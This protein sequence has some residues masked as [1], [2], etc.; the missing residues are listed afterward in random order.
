MVY[1]PEPVSP[2]RHLEGFKASL[3]LPCLPAYASAALPAVCK[4]RLSLCYVAAPATSYLSLL[5]AV[6]VSGS[7]DALADCSAQLY[8]LEGVQAFGNPRATVLL[9]NCG[10]PRA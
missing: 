9:D 7:G 10:G 5:Y 8:L 4:R 2:T 6:K 3:W 1:T